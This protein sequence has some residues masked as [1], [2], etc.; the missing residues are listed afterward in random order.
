MAVAAAGMAVAPAAGALAALPLLAGAAGEESLMFP[1][2]AAIFALTFTS[3][4][5]L[6]PLVSRAA[7]EGRGR[8]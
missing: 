8:A 7:G 5:F 6:G 4:S 3:D 1:S 2:D